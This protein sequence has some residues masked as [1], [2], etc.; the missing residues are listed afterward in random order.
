MKMRQLSERQSHTSISLNFQRT[1]PKLLYSN[2]LT[3]VVNLI[4]MAMSAEDFDIIGL[5]NMVVSNALR[6]FKLSGNET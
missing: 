6:S 5:P 4:I 2:I 3:L 1:P